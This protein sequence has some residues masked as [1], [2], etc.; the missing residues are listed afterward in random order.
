MRLFLSKMK[1]YTHEMRRGESMVILLMF[2]YE[3]ENAHMIHDDILL[4]HWKEFADAL[5]HYEKFNHLEDYGLEC[6]AIRNVQ[7]HQEVMD[8]LAPVLNTTTG[9]KRLSF[10]R[11]N[12]GSEVMSFLADI[13]EHNSYIQGIVWSSNRVES[14]DDMRRFCKSIKKSVS[15]SLKSLG[16]NNCFNGNNREMMRIVVDAT[17][18]LEELSM[19]N[20]GIGFVGATFIANWLASNPPLKELALTGNNLNDTD[21]TLLANA[22]QPNK[23]LDRIYLA[24]NNI[25]AIG[26]RVLLESVFNVTSLNSCAASNH[27]CSILELTPDISKINKYE[28]PP[29]IRAMKIF[30]MLSATD[31]GF[32]NTNYLGDVSYKLI[33]DVLRLTQDF[34]RRTPELSEAYFEQTGQRSADWDQLDVDIVPITSMF[35]LLRGWAVPSLS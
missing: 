16:L 29:I 27:S 24:N 8:M 4:P 20:N 34:T 32:F 33:P 14:L 9:I 6:F 1:D 10:S 23:N 31:E 26:R 11:L 12:V 13:I 35:E 3:N 2:S 22:M 5:V 30:A 17:S 25:T 7:L 19:N 21:A 15:N 18:Q 28:G